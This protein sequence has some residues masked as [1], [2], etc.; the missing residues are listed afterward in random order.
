MISLDSCPGVCKIFSSLSASHPQREGGHRSLSSLCRKEWRSESTVTVH[1]PAIRKDKNEIWPQISEPH[2]AL[3][4]PKH[5]GQIGTCKSSFH[6]NSKELLQ[7]A[8][9]PVT[10]GFPLQR[11]KWGPVQ[12]RWTELYKAITWFRKASVKLIPNF[13]GIMHNPLFFQQF[14]LEKKEHSH[15]TFSIIFM[16]DWPYFQ[17]TSLQDWNKAF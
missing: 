7:S 15:K 11:G 8:L 4:V 3:T 12:W 6:L 2:A 16:S 5:T 14:S 17:S 1:G 9:F 10:V 13:V